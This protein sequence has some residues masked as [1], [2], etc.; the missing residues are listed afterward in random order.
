MCNSR[1]NIMI[2]QICKVNVFTVLLLLLEHRRL[3]FYFIWPMLVWI[4]HLQGEMTHSGFFCLTLMEMQLSVWS[5]RCIQ[6][7]RLKICPQ[8][9]LQDR[10]IVCQTLKRAPNENF[11]F[12]WLDPRQ[13]GIRVWY[14]TAENC[15]GPSLESRVRFRLG[16]GNEAEYWICQRCQHYKIAGIV[17]V[18]VKCFRILI[19]LF[20][21]R[22]LRIWC[23]HDWQYSHSQLASFNIPE[24]TG[25]DIFWASC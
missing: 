1:L 10:M 15:S 25:V 8:K 2:V 22:H 19:G 17:L 11:L 24:N 13:I 3:L 21:S 4:T 16:L 12:L 7:P 6:Q 14:L 18:K 23:S 9:N 20:S 5:Y